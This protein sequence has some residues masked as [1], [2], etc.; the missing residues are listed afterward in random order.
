MGHFHALLCEEF[1][2]STAQPGGS[3]VASFY[4]EVI[5]EP[6]ETD[7]SN[8]TETQNKDDLSALADIQISEHC[9]EDA[10]FNRNMLFPDATD[11]E[12]R[13]PDFSACTPDEI[14]KVSELIKTYSECFATSP[15]DVGTF[16]D[17]QV[18]IKTRPG[19]RVRQRQRTHSRH[20]LEAADELIEKNVPHFETFLG[21]VQDFDTFL[22]SFGH[23][24]QSPRKWLLVRMIFQS[25]HLIFSSNYHKS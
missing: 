14:T 15:Y 25:Y 12:Y 23:H 17:F 16:T 24:K 9:L 19:E 6:P 22:Q 8:L 7:G 3:P 20:A 18:E 10:V 21:I 13:N 4:Q 11:A 2:I 1:N 5:S